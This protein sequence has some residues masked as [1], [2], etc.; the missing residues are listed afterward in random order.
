MTAFSELLTKR[1]VDSD[2]RWAGGAAAS[3]ADEDQRRDRFF[4]T[5]DHPPKGAS[6]HV[7]ALTA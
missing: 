7:A 5:I 4:V 2:R 6:T 3:Q 1:L